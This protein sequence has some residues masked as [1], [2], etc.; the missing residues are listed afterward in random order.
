M[1]RLKEVYLNVCLSK[2]K[3]ATSLK[4]L[5]EANMMTADQIIMIHEKRAFKSDE[6]SLIWKFGN[7][8]GGVHNY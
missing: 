1:E 7:K 8:I 4:T 2:E 5:L 6:K 3:N